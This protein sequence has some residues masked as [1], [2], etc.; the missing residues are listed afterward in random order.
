MLLTTD[1][2]TDALSDEE[3]REVLLAE[4]SDLKKC[5]CKLIENA[6]TRNIGFGDNITLIL[7]GF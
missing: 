6:I 3:I 7:M 2:L 5:G 1:G 4:R